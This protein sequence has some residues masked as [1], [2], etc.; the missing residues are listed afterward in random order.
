MALNDF[1]RATGELITRLQEVPTDVNKRLE[2]LRE[3][4]PTLTQEEQSDLA[5]LPLDKLSLYTRSI[6]SIEASILRN[7]LRRTIREIERCWKDRR[8]EPFNLR[9][10]A[11]TMKSNYPWRGYETLGLLES[12]HDFLT[13]E[14]SDFVSV[15]PWLPDLCTYEIALYHVRRSVKEDADISQSLQISDIEQLTVKELLELSVIIPKRVT[16]LALHVNALDKDDGSSTLSKTRFALVARDKQ[17]SVQTLEVTELIFDFFVESERQR[18][19][20]LGELVQ[21]VL[22]DPSEEPITQFN[23]FYKV[24]RDLLEAG[25]LIAEPFPKPEMG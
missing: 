11:R 2:Y 23:K 8:S 7:R 17:F 19:F 12:F 25:C 18:P 14:L 1:L 5:A 15:A 13:A 9:G 22:H 10:L 24:F 16:P 4:F 21:I 6:F 3:K 20:A